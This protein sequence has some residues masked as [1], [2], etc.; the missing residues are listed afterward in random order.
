MS[1]QLNDK[2]KPIV[3]IQQRYVVIFSIFIV[4]LLIVTVNLTIEFFK[5]RS[6]NGKLVMS[7]KNGESKV[8]R[9]L[10]DKLYSDEKIKIYE[11]QRYIYSSRDPVFS[12]IL[13]CV[14]KKAKEYN[15]SPYLVMAVIKVESNFNT[16]AKSSVAHGLM[17]VNYKVWK[18]DLE[19]DISRLY[20]IEY[21]IDLGLR[22]LKHYKEKEGGDI[23]KALFRYNNGY[24]YNNIKY[25][26]QIIR[27]FRK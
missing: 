3:I 18:K 2:T 21:N 20:D 23:A 22:I 11:F 13:D 26:P 5:A 6:D 24:I 15:F 27:A 25:V 12:N 19:I 8:A 7:I 10:E 16:R 14:Y 17:Q 4:L 9:L 1:K